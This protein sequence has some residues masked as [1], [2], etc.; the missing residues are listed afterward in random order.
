MFTYK[1]IYC[2]RWTKYLLYLITHCSVNSP[3]II[4]HVTLLK[5]NSFWLKVWWCKEI[6]QHK[7]FFWNNKDDL[8][9]LIR[10]TFP[11]ISSST[12]SASVTWDWLVFNYLV[13]CLKTGGAGHWQLSYIIKHRLLSIIQ[14]GTGMNNIW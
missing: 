5:D 6:K 10:Q 11:P 1:K 13:Q 12:M 8:Q 14:L 7:I 9:Y 3:C 2:Q 4:G